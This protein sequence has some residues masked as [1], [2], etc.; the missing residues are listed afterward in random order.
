MAMMMMMELIWAMKGIPSYRHWNR[1]D[2]MEIFA[3]AEDALEQ[4]EIFAA[5]EDEYWDS[6]HTKQRLWM[7]R[8]SYRRWNRWDSMEIFAAARSRDRETAIT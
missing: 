8:P 3:A 7:Y 2:S 1:W 5:A 4:M 6:V